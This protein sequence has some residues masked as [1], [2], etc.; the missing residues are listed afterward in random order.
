MLILNKDLK[1]NSILSIMF[2]CITNIIYKFW[3]NSIHISK[4]SIDWLYFYY[5][6]HIS[7]TWHAFS[8]HGYEVQSSWCSCLVS[9]GHLVFY[10]SM[11]QQWW[12][13]MSSQYWIPYKGS[14]YL[15]SMLWGMR[16]WGID[17]ILMH[18]YFICLL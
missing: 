6:T 10:I 7:K 14:S 5:F 2:Y 12:W 18:F 8:E 9:H 4:V 17:T 1:I 15:Y 3:I 13:L 11:K 16:R